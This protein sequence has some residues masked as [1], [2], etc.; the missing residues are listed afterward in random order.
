MEDSAVQGLLER[1][2]SD[3]LLQRK[4]M[5]IIWPEEDPS[6]NDQGQQHSSLA[7]SQANEALHHPG[8]QLRGTTQGAW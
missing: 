4:L 6:G 3:P 2:N 5:E 1:L 7:E 8:D